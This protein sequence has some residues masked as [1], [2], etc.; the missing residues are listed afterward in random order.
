MDPNLKDAGGNTLQKNVATSYISTILTSS[1]PQCFLPQL[2]RS[3]RLSLAR[4]P[5]HR[6]TFMNAASLVPNERLVLQIEDRNVPDTAS[7]LLVSFLRSFGCL[8]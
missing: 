4:F 1:I 7:F 6:L 2:L 5:T 3:D 8:T